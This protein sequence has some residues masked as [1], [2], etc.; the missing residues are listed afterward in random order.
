MK[1]TIIGAG[2]NIGQRITKEAASRNHELKLISSKSK[3]FFGLENVKMQEVDIFNTAKLAQAV[4]GSDVVISA[5]NPPQGKEMLLSEASK[6]LISAAKKA[7]IRLIA[8]GGAASLKVNDDTI[9][10][11]TPEFPDAVKPVATAHKVVLDEIYKKENELEWTNVSPSAYI[12][13]GDRTNKFRI[14]GEDLLTD[15]NGD[16]SI[17]MEDFAVG[18]LNEVENKEFIKQRFTIGY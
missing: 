13:E 17:S 9:L 7:N 3:D 4:E 15:D 16:S 5:Y 10:L 14:G 11:D 12:F 18:I 1:I 2:G 6:S 8:V